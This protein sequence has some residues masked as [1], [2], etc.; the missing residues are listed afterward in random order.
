MERR[1]E[2][3]RKNQKLIFDWPRT[4]AL[5]GSEETL[6]FREQTVR[7]MT[8]V[9]EAIRAVA[10]ALVGKRQAI[11]FGKDD[12]PQAR[13]GEADL[14]CSLQSV[15]PRHAEIEEDQVRPVDGC[16]LYSI[17]AVAGGSYD[18][19]PSGEFQVI[20][21]RAKR[22]GGIVGNQ[23][24]NRFCHLGGINPEPRMMNIS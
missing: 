6:D 14:L 22:C 3:S 5:P 10:Q 8:L 1:G 7:Q 2:A 13:T 12:H 17:Q 18:L 23:Y 19:K 11:Q 21:H 16:E 4:V 20:T 15:N 24:T 9:H